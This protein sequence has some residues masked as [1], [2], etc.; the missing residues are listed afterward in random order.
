MLS[1]ILRFLAVVVRLIPLLLILVIS[2]VAVS[3]FIDHVVCS[4]RIDKIRNKTLDPSSLKVKDI[5]NLSSTVGIKCLKDC[6]KIKSIFTSL[7]WGFDREGYDQ[8]FEVHSLESSF[9]QFDKVES[10]MSGEQKLRLYSLLERWVKHGDNVALLR[11][12]LSAFDG[13]ENTFSVQD[14]FGSF[15]D[16]VQTIIKDYRT[17]QSE[18]LTLLDDVAQNIRNVGSIT[19]SASGS[20]SQDNFQSAFDA[21]G[22]AA[23]VCS[24]MTVKNQ[25]SCLLE[26]IT[27]YLKSDK[28]EP[29]LTNRLHSYYLPTLTLVIENLNTSCKKKN[30]NKITQMETLCLS[31]IQTLNDVLQNWE[32]SHTEDLLLETEVEVETLQKVAALNDVSPITFTGMNNH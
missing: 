25:L 20:S 7:Q 16:L 30:S 10:Y 27:E 23:A 2:T 1:I 29:E 9:R 22:K 12:S 17:L 19:V 13:L 18:L 28:K 6:K 8:L 4:N 14:S 32:K 24:N 31:A 26:R 11:K 3:L 5:S 21:L 15:D